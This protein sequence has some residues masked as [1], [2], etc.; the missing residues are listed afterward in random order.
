MA[1]FLA[2]FPQRVHLIPKGHPD[3]LKFFGIKISDTHG[4]RQ[5]TRHRHLG[6]FASASLYEVI[7]PSTQ[8]STQ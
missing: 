7:K 1:G 8:P 4:M 2:Q 3:V 6:H 5:Q